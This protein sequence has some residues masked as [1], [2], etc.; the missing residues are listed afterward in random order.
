MQPFSRVKSIQGFWTWILLLKVEFKTKESLWFPF[1]RNPDDNRAGGAVILVD[2]G[3][4]DHVGFSLEID[5][6]SLAGGMEV[7]SLGNY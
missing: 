2:H 6:Y 5:P 1:R 3:A 4:I 7:R